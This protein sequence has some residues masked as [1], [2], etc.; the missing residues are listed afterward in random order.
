[1][2]NEENGDSKKEN[3]EDT[4]QVIRGVTGRGTDNKMA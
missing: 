3:N 1:L 2:L 4:K